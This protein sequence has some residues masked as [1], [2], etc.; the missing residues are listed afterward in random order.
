MK[1]HQTEEVKTTQTVDGRS[2]R[3]FLTT[4]GKLIGLGILTRFTLIG[5]TIAADDPQQRDLCGN[6]AQEQNTCGTRSQ[7]YSCSANNLHKCNA[8]SY[9]D[10][11]GDFTCA[12]PSPNISNCHP[13]VFNKTE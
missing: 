9:F 2:R 7:V 10:C 11:A 4:A 8:T 13:V 3:V 5:K 12:A 6:Q 1:K